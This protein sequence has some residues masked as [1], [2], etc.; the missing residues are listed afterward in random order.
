VPADPSNGILP[1]CESRDSEAVSRRRPRWSGLDS[2]SRFA[3][4]GGRLPFHSDPGDQG[5]I[6]LRRSGGNRFGQSELVKGLIMSFRLVRRPA[7]TLIELLVSIAI[8]GILVALLLP[9]VQSARSAARR[10][11]CKN[12]LRQ[13]A[14]AL[15][16]YH[17]THRCFPPGSYEM[18]S[19]FPM[20]TGWGWGAMLLS[21]LEQNAVYEQIYF[22]QGTAVDGNLALIALPLQAFRCPSEIGP[23]RIH[24]TPTGETAYD[25]A[26]GNYCGSEGVLCAMSNI[27]I[28]QITDGTT[29]TF[30]L[31]ERIVQPST[32]SSLP[33]TS[34]W[35]GQV[36]FAD[37]YDYRSVPH[38][39][40]SSIHMLNSSLTDPQC[41]GS[42]DELGAHFALADGSV[43]F[44]SNS[45]DANVYVALGTADGGEMIS[46][47]PQ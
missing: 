30:M 22:G 42:R 34:A 47:D 9:A 10:T 31:G 19:A 44:I 27:R 18:G 25:L 7:F 8:I 40:P 16:L 35:C 32:P 15:H 17:E 46:F 39:M 41:F 37:Q 20:Q 13:L 38:L 45:I 5:R 23:D 29:Q 33:F 26:S 43:Q 3:T 2:C 14:V 12:Q 11:I 24:C 1:V 36:A 21:Q 4:L 28:A 6:A